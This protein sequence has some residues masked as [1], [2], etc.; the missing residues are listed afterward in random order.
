MVSPC[1]QAGSPLISTVCEPSTMTPG[2]CGDVY[3]TTYW[4]DDTDIRY[5]GSYQGDALLRID[6]DSLAIE[7]LGV[8][9]PEHGLPTLAGWQ[10]QVLYGEA[11]D[12][13]VLGP[14][15]IQRAS[16]V[17]PDEDGRWWSDLSPVNGPRL[18]PFPRRSDALAAEAA[19]LE[20]H[21]FEPQSLPIGA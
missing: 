6:P 16:H 14:T 17:E 21:L 8:P 18:G 4:G 9:V 7:S 1:R 3:V 15:S 2:P 11:V 10:G 19:W 12:L 5:E 20:E 13:G